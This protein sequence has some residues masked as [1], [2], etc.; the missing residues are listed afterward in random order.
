MLCLESR[1]PPRSIA[2]LILKI[3][4]KLMK[5]QDFKG[6]NIPLKDQIDKGNSN[7]MHDE[8]I[9]SV[10]LVQ[11]GKLLHKQYEMLPVLSEVQFV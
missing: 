11:T 8:R 5:L 7:G 10:V 2:A 3:G 1:P 9:Y 6:G 4:Q